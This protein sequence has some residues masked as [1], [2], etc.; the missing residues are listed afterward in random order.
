[1]VALWRVGRVVKGQAVG[2]SAEVRLLYAREGLCWLLVIRLGGRFSPGT[3]GCGPWGIWL[4]FWAT[5]GGSVGP[6]APPAGLGD[7]GAGGGGAG[8]DIVVVCPL[9]LVIVTTFVVLLITTVLWML[10]KITLF[11]GGGAT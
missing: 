6:M 3:P 10:L 4:A 2:Q 11:G 8:G 5:D 7:P 9:R 1:M